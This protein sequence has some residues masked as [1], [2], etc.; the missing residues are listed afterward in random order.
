MGRESEDSNSFPSLDGRGRKGE[1]AAGLILKYHIRLRLVG[2][3][4]IVTRN[5][6]RQG[7]GFLRYFK[8][9]C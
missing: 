9:A 6:L 1:R 8:K 7:H 5:F 2:T 3:I 4:P